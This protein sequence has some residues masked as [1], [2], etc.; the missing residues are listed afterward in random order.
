MDRRA[1]ITGVLALGLV[2]GS[3]SAAFAG[4]T[5]GNGEPNDN[6][7]KAHSEC[8]YSGLDVADAI[9]GNPPAFNDDA[10]SKRGNQAPGG[11]DRYHGVQNWGAYVVYGSS[12]FLTSIGLHPGQA[13][14]GNATH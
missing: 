14:R 4:E 11:K 5:R 10:S 13:C 3:G 7:G 12:D 9:E 1:V 6:Q 2:F 8:H